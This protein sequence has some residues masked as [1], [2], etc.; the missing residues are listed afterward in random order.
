MGL[1]ETAL[2]AQLQMVIGFFTLWLVK[3][4]RFICV[5]LAVKLCHLLKRLNLRYT[6]L[7]TMGE[8]AWAFKG[9][10]SILANKTDII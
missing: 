3:P 4:E 9:V 2:V 10:V 6:H 7:N 1:L 5:G 8:C